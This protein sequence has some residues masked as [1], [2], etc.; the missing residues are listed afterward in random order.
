ARWLQACE[1][2]QV[3]ATD[4]L[5]KDAFRTAYEQ[6]NW[7][8]E[9]LAFC[10]ALEVEMPITS[11]SRAANIARWLEW[12]QD[13]ADTIDPTGGLADT[14]FDVDAEPNDLRPFLGDWSPHRP[15]REFRTATD[16]Q[17]LEAIR[18]SVAPWHPGMRGQ[19]WRHH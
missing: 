16:E 18:E 2:A 17:S 5:R 12:A 9:I 3:K 8:R 19:W 11:K 15:E 1:R 7:R 10:A 13:I 6:W 14:T 4:K